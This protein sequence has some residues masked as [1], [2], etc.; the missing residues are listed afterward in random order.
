[1]QRLGSGSMN[2]CLVTNTTIMHCSLSTIT[3]V[4]LD[5]SAGAAETKPKCKT[6]KM[7]QQFYNLNFKNLFYSFFHTGTWIT[8]AKFTE[9]QTKTVGLRIWKV[10]RHTANQQY[11][12]LRWL[13]AEL[14][15]KSCY[16]F[17][18][19]NYSWFGYNLIA[20]S[21][22]KPTSSILKDKTRSCSHRQHSRLHVSWK[23]P[24]SC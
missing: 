23:P 6:S 14:D 22:Q 12:N 2:Y 7:C 10:W 19:D 17:K 18:L 15:Q 16:I 8:C 24:C 1:M 4:G 20:A 9:N 13:Q 11:N 5:C 21:C 3:P